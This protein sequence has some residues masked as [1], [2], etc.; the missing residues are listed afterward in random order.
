[1]K[2]MRELDLGATLAHKNVVEGEDSLRAFS[3][4]AVVADKKRL[5]S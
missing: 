4:F 5:E 1:M 2:P 3:A